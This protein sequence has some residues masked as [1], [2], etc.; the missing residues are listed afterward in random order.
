MPH[1]TLANTTSRQKMYPTENGYEETITIDRRGEEKLPS[2]HQSCP[3]E[4]IEEYVLIALWVP[5][6][7]RAYKCLE[8]LQFG[9]G[10]ESGGV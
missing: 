7:E 10:V 5:L 9:E 6:L 1:G 3:T 4:A 2:L 8:A